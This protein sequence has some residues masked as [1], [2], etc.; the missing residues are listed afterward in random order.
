MIGNVSVDQ[1][2]ATTLNDQGSNTG[3]WLDN[4]SPGQTPAST[5]SGSVLT[6]GPRAAG[7]VAIADDSFFAFKPERF[8]GV[9]QVWTSGASATYGMARF[10]AVGTADCDLVGSV[11]T[12]DV[13]VTT[14]ALAGTT[15]TDAKLTISAANTGIIYIE[16]RLGS[17]KTIDF[18]VF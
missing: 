18:S 5:R 12:A 8:Q 2:F 1:V 6:E 15:G 13:E 7:T 16:N 3:F 17:S 4:L 9:V 10:I 14:G 11:S